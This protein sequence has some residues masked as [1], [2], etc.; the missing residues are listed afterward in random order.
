MCEHMEQV[1][2]RITSSWI[3][4]SPWYSSILVRIEIHA[5]IVTGDIIDGNDTDES[6]KKDLEHV[7]EVFAKNNH[8]HYHVVGN[9][10][11]RVPRDY[12]MRELKMQETYYD[13]VIKDKWRFIVLDG[14]DI[15]TFGW[16]SETENFKEAKVV[17]IFFPFK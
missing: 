13:F 8:R 10:C 7:L 16:D 9:H 6:T 1:L 17:I 5:W 3:Y 15:S 4:S 12:L 11:L 14:T 2:Q